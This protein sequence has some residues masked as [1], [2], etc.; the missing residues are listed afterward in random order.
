MG[1]LKRT[2]LRYRAYRIAEEFSKLRQQQFDSTVKA[3][4]SKLRHQLVNGT[5]GG[6]ADRALKG[7]QLCISSAFFA[8]RPNL[9]P[10]SEFR[11]FSEHLSTAVVGLPDEKVLD[12][13]KEFA[14][15]PNPTKQV[16]S[17]SAPIA[18]YITSDEDPDSDVILIV[19]QLLLIFAVN[20]Q[21][22]VASIFGERE[23]VRELEDEM[24]SIRRGLTRG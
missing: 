3:I 19:A 6:E 22:V 23:A 24:Q 7:Y 14:H 21:M 17:V 2:Y 8:L 15:A 13:F 1:L 5:L 10:A 16:V 11:D 20:S 18:N 4:E 9:I 12:Y